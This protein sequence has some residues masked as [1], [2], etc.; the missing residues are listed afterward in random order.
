MRRI[1]PAAVFVALAVVLA[2]C[3]G[4]K[5][6]A[7]AVAS[8]T[9]VSTAP[10]PPPIAPLTGAPDPSGAA[11]KRCAVT[12]KIDNTASGHPKY[13]VE[14]ADVVYE[15]VVEGGITRLAAVFNSQA[16]DRVGPVRSVRKTDQSIVRP[17]R[18]IFVYSGGAPYAI[19][20]I[21][22]APVVQLD[23]TRS[24]S[25][26]FRD[27]ARRP[28]WNLYAH[29]DQ[30][31]ARCGPIVPPP[32]LF[33]YTSPSSPPQSGT[34]VSSVRVG[35]LNGFAV[36]WKWDAASG[37]W[38]RNIFGSPEITAT[39]TQFAPKNVVVMFAQYVGGD[40]NHGNEGAEATLT[41][42][43]KLLVF[44]NGQEISGSWSRPD[45]TQP[46]QLLDAAGVPITLTPGQTW[47]EIPDAG[48]SVT[49]AP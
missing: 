46:A 31:Y 38:K 35:F 30:M 8:V 9:T 24:G 23:E 37:T 25:M 7:V 21:N 12:V 17:Y 36:T 49:T 40:P 47:V 18:G 27:R 10:P 5:H 44:T 48:Y 20:S 34:A 3:S 13:G 29:V 6:K 41:G 42:T 22:T 16:P 11:Q 45:E 1:A 26:M 28:P 14:Q 15:E 19:A 4:A 39:G 32:N 43:G 33:S 2:G